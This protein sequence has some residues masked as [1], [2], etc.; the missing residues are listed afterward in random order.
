MKTREI[1]FWGESFPFCYFY[2]LFFENYA[3]TISSSLGRS[4][5]QKL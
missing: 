5:L 4:Q 2:E 1:F 3:R